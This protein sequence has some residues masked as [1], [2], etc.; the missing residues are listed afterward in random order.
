MAEIGKTRIAELVKMRILT[1]G[2][3]LR[4]KP[5]VR[6]KARVGGYA[7]DRGSVVPRFLKIDSKL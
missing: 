2:K 7:Q 4:Y 3:P 1:C 6:Y 5:V